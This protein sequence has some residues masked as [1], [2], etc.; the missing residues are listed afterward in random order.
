MRSP[1][2]LYRIRRTVA[3]VAG[4][5]DTRK[6]C[7][8]VRWFQAHEHFWTVNNMV[9]ALYRRRSARWIVFQTRFSI[10][11]RQYFVLVLQKMDSIQ[12]WFHETQNREPTIRIQMLQ[13]RSHRGTNP[14]RDGSRKTVC[15]LTVTPMTKF[16]WGITVLDG[17]LVCEETIR[18]FI[19]GKTTVLANSTAWY[20]SDM[21]TVAGNVSDNH[22][23]I[24]SALW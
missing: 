8:K 5:L 15:A 23:W 12:F 18:C 4:G 14:P 20:S 11:Q 6:S 21:R 17:R 24:Y 22:C 3:W 9:P 19:S 16:I 7:R 13:D 1:S 2:L 10:R